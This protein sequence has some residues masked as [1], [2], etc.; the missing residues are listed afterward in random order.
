VDTAVTHDGSTAD[1]SSSTDSD[2]DGIDD[3][4]DNC[5]QKPN[6]D[7]RD[8]DGDGIGDACDDDIDGDGVK[9]AIDNCRN[10]SNPE[11][12]DTDGDGEGNVCDSDDDGDEIAD[13]QDNCPTTANPDQID[14]DGDGEG[15][16]CE[17]DADGDGYSPPED[18]DDNDPD[19]NPDVA[20]ACNG[21][22]DN[23]DGVTDFAPDGWEPNETAATAK[24]LGGVSDCGG[25]K[26][27]TDAN[28]SP[29]SDLDW[30]K[31]H[32]SDDSFCFI[33]PEAELTANPGDFTICIFFECDDGSNASF[34][35]ENGTKV[36]G[37]GPNSGPFAPDGC[38]SHSRVKLNH[39][40][41]TGADD[42][43]DIYIKVFSDNNT[44]CESYNLRAGDDG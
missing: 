31:L 13:D 29:Q 17:D 35:C 42:S 39:D 44:S 26:T 10:E 28:L 38:C 7:Q 19:R 14:S 9:N 8:R 36:T 27:V 23:C 15:D 1:V 2:R 4:D 5:P 40:C 24:D 33:Y 41:G 22:D 11:Q 32:V 43:A 30:Y 25:W 18:C 37:E 6:S 20:E 16:L 12:I 21:I 3:L 34:S